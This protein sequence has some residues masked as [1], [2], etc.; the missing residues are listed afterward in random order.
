[1]RVAI[2]GVGTVGNEVAN[3][4]LRNQKLISARSGMNITPVVGVVRD[5]NK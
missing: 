1:M 4:L 5:L 3:V 2:L